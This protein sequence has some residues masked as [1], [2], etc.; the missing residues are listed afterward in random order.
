MNKIQKIL[1]HAA[2]FMAAILSLS[3]CYENVIDETIDESEV[4]MEFKDIQVISQ[5]NVNDLPEDVQVSDLKVLSLSG[6]ESLDN[7]GLAEVMTFE[8]YLPQLLMVS[9]SNDDI[10]LMARGD[11]HDGE[12]I[13]ISARS[14]AIALVTMHPALSGVKS[15]VYQQLVQLVTESSSFEDLLKVIEELVRNGHSFV[16]SDNQVL[17][18][19]LNTVFEQVVASSE[20][21][22]S[23]G[24]L[25]NEGLEAELYSSLM[26]RAPEL[27]GVTTIAGINV[28]PFHVT[29]SGPKVII[30][31]YSLTPFYSGTVTHHDQIEEFDI[32]SGGDRGVSFFFDNSWGSEKVDYKFVQEGEYQFYFDKTTVESIFD[33][34]RNTVCNVLEVLGLP[35]DKKWI[36]KTA[37]DMLRFWTA[38]GFDVMG[39]LTSPNTDAWDITFTVCMGVADYIKEGCLEAMLKQIGMKAAAATMAQTVLKKVVAV[40]SVYQS[41]R[42]AINAV[43]RITMRLESPD[44]VSFGLY[45]YQGE[46][47][48]ATKAS[49]EIYSGDYQEG[50][51]GRRLNEPVRVKVTTIGSDGSEVAASNFHKIKFETDEYNGYAHDEIVSTDPDGYAQ[52]FWTLDPYNAEP[53]YLKAT[54]I[55]IVTGEVISD[56]VVFCACPLQAADVTFTLDWSPTDSNCDIDLHV[57]DPDGHHICYYDM[58]CGCGGYLDRDDVHGPGPEHIYYTEAKPGKYTVYVHHYNSDTQGTVGFSVTTE[59]DERCFVNR[60]SVSYLDM[61]YIGTLEV[62]SVPASPESRAGQ[63]KP[64]AR[65]YYDENAP[66][67]P[68]ESFP[69]KG[70]IAKNGR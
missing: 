55:D 61:V 58:W 48:T 11:F 68:V 10:L 7:Q 33:Q 24:E 42:G 18:T 21:D 36:L 22:T 37:D 66:A 14:T 67:N 46:I 28:G 44:N 20:E 23:D 65:F 12:K 35:L 45:Y 3:S 51:I 9:N 63:Q 4:S 39:L 29:T 53:Q 47:T 2:T 31:N 13:E 32:P 70:I 6:E 64:V 56:E 1:L 57:Y 8:G 41:C 26:T 27:K 38:R 34:A 16:D 43:M 5:V 49:L 15:H 17:T 25:P 30:E 54:V 59:Y 50:L 40:Y 69:E 60:G 19:A 62:E 52:T